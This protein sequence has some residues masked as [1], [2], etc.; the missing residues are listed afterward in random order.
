MTKTGAIPA[1]ISFLFFLFFGLNF[2]FSQS[3]KFSW[4]VCLPVKSE[5]KAVDFFRA[6][7]E[8]DQEQ[9]ILNFEFFNYFKRDSERLR[10]LLKEFREVSLFGGELNNTTNLLTPQQIDSLGN[11]LNQV[12]GKYLI[13][14]FRKRDSYPPGKEEIIQTAQILNQLS[15]RLRKFGVFLIVKNNMGSICQTIDE[16]QAFSHATSK[17]VYLMMDV[18]NFVQ[19]GGDPILFCSKNKRRIKFFVFQGLISPVPGFSGP[20]VKNF[21]FIDLSTKSNKIEFKTLFSGLRKMGIKAKA[22]LRVSDGSDVSSFK[23]SLELQ[24]NFLKQEFGISLN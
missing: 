23:K 22:F 9:V 8:V 4:G 18:A 1:S 21:Q 17:R 11:F 24:S 20:S 2:S 7:D 14:S 6:L 3:P 13:L 12:G 10:I 16:F 19:A 15:D 5:E